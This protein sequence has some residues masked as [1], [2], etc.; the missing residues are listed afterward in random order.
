M[1]S[2]DEDPKEARSAYTWEIRRCPLFVKFD[3][4]VFVLYDT[5]KPPRCAVRKE[6]SWRYLILEAADWLRSEVTRPGGS[7]YIRN[8]TLSI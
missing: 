1:V 6:T 4:G 3:C 5:D 8:H 7:K 2:L